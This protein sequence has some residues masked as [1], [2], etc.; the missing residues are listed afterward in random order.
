MDPLLRASGLRGYPA[1]MRDMGCDPVPLLRRYHITEAALER[2]DTLISLR[3]ATHL[4][5]ASAEV[6]GC[7]DFGLRLSSYQSI[8]VLGPLSVVLRN[9]PTI[10]DALNDVMHYLFVHS[11]GIV[12]SVNE[13][14]RLVENTVAVSVE[15]HLSGPV[16]TRQNSDLCLADAHNFLRLFAG[17]RYALQAVSIPHEPVVGRAVYERFFGARLLEEPVG[18]TLYLARDTFAANVQGANASFHQIAEDYIFRNFGAAQGRTSDRVRQVL[19][20]TLGT[21]SADKAG[22]A[23]VLALHPRTLQRRLCAEGTSF[24]IL[25]DDVR[26]QLAVHYLRNTRLSIGQISLMLGFPAQSALSRACRQ[27]FDL[28]PSE[29]RVGNRPT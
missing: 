1:L 4:L 7:G 25:R 10:R 18:A 5:E 20:Q 14:S 9:A 22:V 15:L 12:V 29:I 28:T 24:E 17:D 13:R 11:P 27:W 2:D 3:S 26:K 19:R 6:T 21:S 23:A 16:V 8:D